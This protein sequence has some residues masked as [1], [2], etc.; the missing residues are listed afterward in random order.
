MSALKQLEEVYLD[1]IN[2]PGFKKKFIELLDYAGRPTPLFF[3]K[4]L[5]DHLGG[6][7]IYIKNEGLLHTGA[8][9]LNNALGQSLLAQRMQ[10]KTLIAETGAGQH[11][12]ATSTAAARSQMGCR[13]FMGEVDM[14]RQYPNVYNMKLLGTKVM[15]VKEGTRTLKDAVNAAL[16]DWIE[17][18]DDCHY[19][20]GSALG[21]HP[22][23]TIV[24]DF[25]SIIGREVKE[26]FNGL[27][28]KL[29]DLI[30][31]CV[32]GGSNSLGIFHSFIDEDVKLIG[33]EAGG[34]GEE[35]GEHASRFL[36][37]KIGIAQGYKSYFIQ[38]E[39]GQ[40]SQTHSISAGL[41]YGGISPELAYLHDQK[42]VE[43]MRATDQE[44][45][46][47]F[48]LLIKTEGVIPAMESSH[49]VAGAIR[50]AKNMPREKSMVV[51]ISGRG[52][53]DLFITAKHLDLKNWNEF[54]KQEIEEMS[55]D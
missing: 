18:L 55:N 49:A 15:A 32:G 41:D 30:I 39:E 19:I 51:H 17:H 44:A 47:A 11:G 45:L 27:T 54:L 42:R 21:P 23:P 33:V 2:D 34:R 4:S 46:D 29:P 9:K 52:D 20:I 24:R 38:N 14:K 22:Y 8:H 25:Q 5:S 3:A 12:L 36:H 43:F 13:V 53:K 37:P 35:M 28:G 7:K 48:K 6:A 40:L 1:A 50:L 10:K 26:Q 31:A 16:K